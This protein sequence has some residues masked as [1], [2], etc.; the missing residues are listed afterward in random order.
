MIRYTVL[1]ALSLMPYTL[2]ASDDAE[3]Q[4]WTADVPSGDEVPVNWLDNS[5]AYLTNQTQS[6]AG[7]MDG[8]FGDPEHDADKAESF[9]RLE[10]I[11]DWH[12]V[13]DN[14]LK[15]KIRGRVQL[16][17][18]SKRLALVFSGEETASPANP[19]RIEMMTILVSSFVPGKLQRLELTSRWV[20]LPVI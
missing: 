2:A 14:D 1:L 12:S 7:W 13:D 4:G 9:I 3:I 8:F 10:L 15:L 6:L 16:P 18:L 11:E 19:Y 17:M 5:H 20:T